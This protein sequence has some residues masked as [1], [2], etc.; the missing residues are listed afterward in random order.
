[1]ILALLKTLVQVR[2]LTKQNQVSAH[3]I[4]VCEKTS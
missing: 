1:M 2:I 4:K 3:F